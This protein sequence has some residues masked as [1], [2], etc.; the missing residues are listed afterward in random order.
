[1][2]FRR[3]RSIEKT[4]E[5]QQMYLSRIED[6]VSDLRIASTRVLQNQ[7]SLLKWAKET[8][9]TLNEVDAFVSDSRA[10]EEILSKLE[11]VKQAI[12]AIPR[13]IKIRNIFD[14][15]K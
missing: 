14:L 11:E 5:T 15:T 1:M 6:V 3:L 8:E 4:L 2:I 9:Q 10:F 7:V 12:N 13:E